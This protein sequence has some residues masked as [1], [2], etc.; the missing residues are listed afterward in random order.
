MA[1]P[2]LYK[3]AY[4]DLGITVSVGYIGIQGVNFVW[5]TQII[6]VED[7]PKMFYQQT[8]QK[9]WSMDHVADLVADYHRSFPSALK[10][11]HGRAS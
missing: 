11:K 10:E 1:D 5:V 6:G 4:K 9:Q 8:T 2:E 7:K 3:K